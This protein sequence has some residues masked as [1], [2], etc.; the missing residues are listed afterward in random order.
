MSYLMRSTQFTEFLSKE[1]IVGIILLLL[2]WQ[3]RG[4]VGG[5]GGKGGGRVGGRGKIGGR[6]GRRIWY[7]KS[8]LSV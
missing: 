6:G 5:R 1:S 2:W 3:R 7:F 4:R 8:K